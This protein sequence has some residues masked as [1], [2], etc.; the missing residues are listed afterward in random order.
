VS[1]TTLSPERNVAK[2][3][4]ARPPA[5]PPEDD[6]VT[7]QLRVDR[8]FLAELQATSKRFGLSASAYIRTRMLD[9]MR[10]DN[11]ELDAE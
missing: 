11:R 10:R 2:K 4:P 8:A 6:R 1:P 3:R 7:F 5:R 9:A